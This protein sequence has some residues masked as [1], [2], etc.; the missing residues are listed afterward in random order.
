MN[1][2]QVL[3]ESEHLFPDDGEAKVARFNDTGVDRT[4]WDFVH[5]VALHGHEGVVVN[6]GYRA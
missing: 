1:I 2:P 3:L 6:D 5:T 4:H